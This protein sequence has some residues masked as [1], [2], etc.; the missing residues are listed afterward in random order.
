MAVNPKSLE[1]LKKDFTAEERRENGRKG[2]TASGKKR[3]ERKSAREQAVELLNGKLPK[4]Y[5][6]G[7][8]RALMIAQLIDIAEHGESEKDRIAAVKLLFELA[9]EDSEY[10]IRK[11]RADNEEF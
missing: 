2:G 3:A 1:N 6:S 4:E 10:E 11:Q 7:T 5:G 8:Y 9:R